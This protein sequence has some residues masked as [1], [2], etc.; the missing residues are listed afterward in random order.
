LYTECNADIESST[1]IWNKYWDNI[2]NTIQWYLDVTNPLI[3]RV[4]DAGWNNYLNNARIAKIEIVV[5][6]AY[7]DWAGE[8]I[9]IP[10]DPYA[11]QAVPSCPIKTADASNPDP[12][13]KKPK[14][15]KQFED[16]NCKDEDYP[17]GILG[18]I[19]ENCHFTKITIGPKIGP[20]Q[21]GFTY[22]TN[23]DLLTGEVKDPIYSQN[24]DFAKSFGATAGI[25]YKFDE[26]VELGG[27][28][29]GSVTYDQQGKSSGYTASAEGAGA[30]DIGI[31]KLGAK[32][33]RTWQM[34]GDGNL[35]GYSNSITGSGQFL[36]NAGFEGSE[37]GTGVTANG[38]YNITSNYDQFGNY[39][40][41][42]RS[43]TVSVQGG[44]TSNTAEAN[45][46]VSGQNT[47]FAVQANQ[48]IQV[49]A[50][51]TQGS[52]ITVTGK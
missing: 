27:T 25:A 1:R 50:G 19:T 38:E 33:S 40:G 9:N 35:T 26:V 21:L 46:E 44:G 51:K 45:H 32:A 41:G 7:A 37:M 2:F 12:F 36:N 4:H 16:P 6:T 47:F 31:A 20:V 18:T 11:N 5:L 24:N 17:I 8:V 34:D 39:V 43:A 48:V 49:V 29:G 28:V 23:K 30:L 52:P 22:G 3:K 14:H 10:I 15:I 13:S 42:N